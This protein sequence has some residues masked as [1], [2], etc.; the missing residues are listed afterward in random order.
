MVGYFYAVAINFGVSARFVKNEEEIK[1][2]N[3]WGLVAKVDN[4]FLGTFAAT[5]GINMVANFIPLSYDLANLIPSEINFK[6]GGLM[7]AG[8]DFS[9]VIGGMWVSVITQM[10]LFPFIKTLGAILAPVSGIMMVNYY[11]IKKEDLD[12]EALFDDSPDAKYH[13]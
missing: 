2:R 8:F 3:L 7:T 6:T 11:L 12:V 5:I 1:K 4:V 10:G 9:F 13:Y